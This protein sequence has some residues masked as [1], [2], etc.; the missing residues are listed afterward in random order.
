ML[1]AQSSKRYV[2]VMP[3]VH[4]VYDVLVVFHFIYYTNNKII[5]TSAYITA[6]MIYVSNCIVCEAGKQ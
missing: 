4:K 1:S 6:M 3:K 2:H 5:S